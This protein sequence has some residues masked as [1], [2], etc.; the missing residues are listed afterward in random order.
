MKLHDLKTRQNGFTR[1]SQDR[2]N[3]M[4]NIVDMFQKNEISSKKFRF[5]A[6]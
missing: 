2:S 3:R 6:G 5:L 1:R 4:R